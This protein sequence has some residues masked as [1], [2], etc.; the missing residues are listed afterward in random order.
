VA[1]APRATR[2]APRVDGLGCVLELA[3]GTF[4]GVSRLAAD[5]MFGI[6]PVNTNKGS[7]G[8]VCSMGNA[9]SPRG[10]ESARRAMRA[11]V[12]RRHD[13]E[14]VVRQTLRMR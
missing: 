14:P 11:D 9:S 5:I 10:C 6:S 1:V 4:C 3:A 2:G 13:R 7:K 12:L 8:F